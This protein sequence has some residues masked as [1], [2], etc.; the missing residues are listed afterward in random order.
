MDPNYLTRDIYFHDELIILK[1]YLIFIISIF[2][3]NVQAIAGP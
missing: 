1:Y 2:T 3:Q